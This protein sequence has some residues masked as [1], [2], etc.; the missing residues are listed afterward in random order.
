MRGMWKHLERLGGGRAGGVGTR[1]PGESQLES[2]RRMARRRISQLRRRLKG[3]RHSAARRKERKRAEAPTVALAGYT[4]VGKSTLLNALTGAE[5]SR[6]EPALRDARPDHARLRARR[7][8]V[9]RHRH[10]RLHPAAADPA[11]RGLRVDARGDARRRP[12]SCTSSTPSEDDERLERDDR[13]RRRRAARDRRRRRCRS[14]SCSTRSTGSTRSA[15]VGSRTASR[16]RCRSR[17]D[18]GRARRSCAARI[19]TLFADRFEDVRLL[20][21]VR[22]R[23]QARGALR[24]RRS[25]RRARATRRPAC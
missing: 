3:C 19:A 9:P 7:Q 16:A 14:S 5:V 2:D 4:N 22:G 17:R 23:G 24:A 11:R 13:R 25:D 6:R 18:G 12:R 8:A 15:A 10:G 1:G 20:V 21:P